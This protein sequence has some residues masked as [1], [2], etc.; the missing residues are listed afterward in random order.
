MSSLEKCRA[1][2]STTYTTTSAYAIVIRESVNVSVRSKHS[3]KCILAKKCKAATTTSSTS[4]T[5][6]SDV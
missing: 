5:T 4:S 2:T 1:Y 3:K 6:V